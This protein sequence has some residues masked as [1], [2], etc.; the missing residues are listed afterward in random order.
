KN[1]YRTTWR[2]FSSFLTQRFLGFYA[3]GGYIGVVDEIFSESGVFGAMVVLWTQP[4]GY[5]EEGFIHPHE[6]LWFEFSEDIGYLNVQPDPLA[7]LNFLI[8]DADTLFSDSI[9][10]LIPGIEYEITFMSSDRAPGL[11]D[12]LPYS[13]NRHGMPLASFDISTFDVTFEQTQSFYFT[14]S[15]A[16]ILLPFHEPFSEEPDKWGEHLVELGLDENT[17]IVEV[18]PDVYRVTSTPPV[19]MNGIEQ[20]DIEFDPTNA[21]GMKGINIQARVQE[22]TPRDSDG[23]NDV[24]SVFHDQRLQVH[25]WG[26]LDGSQELQ[27][28]GY[29]EMIVDPIP[30]DADLEPPEYYQYISDYP[31]N[32]ESFWTDGLQG[33]ATDGK[34]LYFTQ[35]DYIPVGKRAQRL[36]AFDIE[37]VEAEGEFSEESCVLDCKSTC[38][39]FGMCKHIGDIDY[40]FHN[41]H[42]YLFVSSYLPVLP[43]YIY[44]PCSFVL[45][46]DMVDGVHEIENWGYAELNSQ[47]DVGWLAVDPKGKYLYTSGSEIKR[48]S[49]P[50]G[51][52]PLLRY[53]INWSK[54]ENQTNDFLEWVS[55]I[56]L[57]DEDGEYYDD[58]NPIED[59]QGGAFAPTGRYLYLS[60]GYEDGDKEKYGIKVFDVRDWRLVDRSST[61]QNDHF[62]YGMPRSEDEPE[63]LTVFDF[64]EQNGWDILSGQLHVLMV[65]NGWDGY[66]DTDEVFLRHYTTSAG[67]ICKM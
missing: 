48:S 23:N 45:R 49:E 13:M 11:G 55:Y 5:T 21:D 66:D 38:S 36:K 7:G 26:Y 15:H 67:D 63:G 53:E 51:S 30:E 31:S 43:P 60:N 50:G 34:Y 56:Y 47:D 17:L 12:Q 1:P 24:F 2:P 40:H 37:R 32:L 57:K 52:M 22:C 58:G 42:G 19:W 6:K 10:G 44:I 64:G 3:T 9:Q 33:V 39:A 29:D 61:Y 28:L 41:G 20:P 65:R 16:R 4:L 46:T 59:M 27:W 14:T 35:N 8:E 25:A 18:S 62:W 54:L